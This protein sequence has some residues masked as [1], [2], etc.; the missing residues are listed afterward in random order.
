MHLLPKTSSW[1]GRGCHVVLTRTGVTGGPSSEAVLP[2]SR[3]YLLSFQMCM[4][5]GMQMDRKRMEREEDTGQEFIRVM[6]VPE[7]IE[8]PVG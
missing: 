4:Q 6:Q 8:W 5:P 2:V 7:I 3:K 1:T